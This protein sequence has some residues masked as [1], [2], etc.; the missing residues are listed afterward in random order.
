MN[1]IKRYRDNGYDWLKHEGDS[2]VSKEIKMIQLMSTKT[3]KAL[4]AS[5]LVGLFILYL[6]FISL[7][8]VSFVLEWA[9]WARICCVG[10]RIYE[11]IMMLLVSIL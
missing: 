3:A 6:L 2:R 10:W 9:S 7:S 4:S 11:V 5:H 1:E 8:M